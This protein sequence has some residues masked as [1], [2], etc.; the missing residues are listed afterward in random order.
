MRFQGCGH[1]RD[2]RLGQPEVEQ[3]RAR[4]RQHDV[5]RLQIAMHN[6]VPV[7]LV[8][9]VRNLNPVTDRLLHGERSFLESPGER[10]PLEI[11]HDQEGHALVVA[12]V[13]ER[14]DVRMTELRDRLRFAIEPL[15]KLRIDGHAG[16][17]N[18]DGDRAVE[19]RVR[20]PIDFA[21][22]A[23]AVQRD[24]FVRSQSR[25]RRQHAVLSRVEARVISSALSFS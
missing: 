25:A 21:H 18:L 4:L 12:D 17:K 13:I 22:P 16:G 1:R 20:R 6:A 14:A 2:A 10:L 3:L 7:R 8:E 23:G 19:A 24:D 11:F 15:P 9:R 5:A